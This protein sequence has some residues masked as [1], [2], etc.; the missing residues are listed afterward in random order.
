[1]DAVSEHSEPTATRGA[2]DQ[3]LAAAV[4][5]LVGFGVVMIYSSSA[6]FAQRNLEDAQY[7][8]NKQMM[9]A[10]VGVAV[11]LVMSRIGY[12]AAARLA[13]PLLAASVI[14]LV[15][16]MTPLGTSVNGAQ[17]WL[18]VAGF[19]F[20]PGELAK[21]TIV[22]WLAYSLT[23][24]APKIKTFSVGFL[25]HVL[26]AGLL[27]GLVFLEPDLGTAVLIGVTTVV[28][29]FVAGGKVLYLLGGL[30]LALPVVYFFIT[31]SPYRMARMNAF[32]DP[33]AHRFGDGYQITE[34][35]LGFGAGGLWGL[36]LGDGRQKLFFLPEAHNDFI[37]S[38]IGEELGFVGLCALIAVFCFIVWR[39][40]RI[41]MRN[42][43]TF[44]SY[45][46]FGITALIGV[47]ALLNLAVALGVVPTKG[48][49]LPFVSYGG[50]SLL[51]NMISVGILLDVSRGGP[52]P[53]EA[54]VQREQAAA[55]EREAQRQGA[56]R[57]TRRRAAAE[58]G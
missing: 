38:Q 40:L 41:A 36:G 1:M 4:L 3:V 34:S 43:G 58:A 19:T 35:L 16:V 49:N 13:V 32:F 45:L 44:G 31:S 6:V 23:R 33:F 48:L 21:V 12:R 42:P 50:S 10:G 51:F 52:C 7:F 28:M 55:E 5:L 25:P 54:K 47:Q 56:N 8:L 53:L 2:M 57:V 20:Q 27:T 15:L 11:M 14:L 29:L 9:W 37:A 24:K 26:V 17:R 30:A 46:A 39:G 18:R 22:I